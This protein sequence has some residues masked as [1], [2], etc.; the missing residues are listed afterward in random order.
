[1]FPDI[2]APKPGELAVIAAPR[3]SGK[4]TFAVELARAW[5]R[6]RKVVLCVPQ[7]EALPKDLRRQCPD[8]FRIACERGSISDL[9]RDLISDGKLDGPDVLILDEVWLDPEPVTGPGRKRP[10]LKRLAQELR[11]PVIAI[12]NRSSAVDA[13]LAADSLLVT[14]GKVSCATKEPGVGGRWFGGASDAHC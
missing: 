13:V 14:D 2:P 5:G 3:V 4:T 8:L 12:V 10:T 6:E 9:Y 7:I 11:I 1:V